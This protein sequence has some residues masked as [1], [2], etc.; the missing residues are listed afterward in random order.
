LTC[1]W[2]DTGLKD[3]Y[4]VG[5]LLKYKEWRHRDGTFIGVEILV[6]GVIC[7]GSVYRGRR[8]IEGVEVQGGGAK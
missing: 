8:V 2:I 6:W 1:T 3:F 7:I 5:H 4:G